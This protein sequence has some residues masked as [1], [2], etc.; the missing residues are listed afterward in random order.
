MNQNYDG[1][2]CVPGV[3]GTIGTIFSHAL[4]KAKSESKTK[5]I[6]AS[7]ENLQDSMDVISHQPSKWDDLEYCHMTHDFWGGFGTYMCQHVK[8]KTM[9]KFSWGNKTASN[10]GV[11]SSK[12]AST[13]TSSNN[14]S[15]SCLSNESD[16]LLT[17]FGPG[18]STQDEAKDVVDLG[19][20]I[21]FQSLF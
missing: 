10:K 6:A 2:S 13:V 3:T 8:N 16:I 19:E 9:V 12:V 5:R 17:K 11:R 15:Q 20:F 4:E 1:I 18:K 7:L 21:N 14:V